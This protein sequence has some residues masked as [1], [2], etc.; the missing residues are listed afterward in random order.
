MTI[1]FA[2]E[3]PD[4]LPVEVPMVCDHENHVDYSE[5]RSLL[6]GDA[7]DVALWLLCSEGW[8]HDAAMLNEYVARLRKIEA[9]ARAL[10]TPGLDDEP[11]P[12][13]EWAPEFLALRAALE[14]DR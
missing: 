2:E 1:R 4:G 12:D 5:D 13:D 14:A 11:L 9:A 8:G 3:G 10:V 7:L 6:R